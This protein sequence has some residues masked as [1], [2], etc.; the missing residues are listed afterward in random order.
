MFTYT[1]IS[2]IL[3]IFLITR[4]L[5]NFV[6]YC[7]YPYGYFYMLC[8]SSIL[9]LHL[10][11]R[12]IMIPITIISGFLG[13]GKTTYLQHILNCG[14]TNERILIIENDFGETSLDAKQLSTSGATVREVTSGC[15]CC[16]LQ[17][18]FKNALIDILS[19]QDIDQIYIEPSGVSKLSEILYT[20]DDDD[21]TSK[22]YVS[23]I[24][25][26]VD[27]MQ[28]PMAIKNFGPFFKDQIKHCYA[29]LLT[30]VEDEKQ[31]EK[32]K[33]LI[34]ELAPHTPVYTDVDALQQDINQ[35]KSNTHKAHEHDSETCSCHTCNDS[36]DYNGA[37]HDNHSHHNH[38]GHHH[39]HQPFVTHTFHNLQSLDDTQ[40]ID[41]C[42]NLPSTILRV[43]GIIPTASG[44][45]ELQY[46]P[47]SCAITATHLNDYHLVVIGTE[48]DIPSI[49]E[50][51]CSA[52]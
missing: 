10:Q 36:E 5:L 12:R 21:I 37:H 35:L 27:A 9:C 45:M 16:S 19:T 32:T 14:N 11:G 47:Q 22:A 49:N 24:I 15:I 39:E 20:C 7:L 30:H 29:M 6:N 25:T 52:S 34:V 4:L 26:V 38:D 44:P 46:T 40:W 41:F 1:H 13:A 8:K 17:G 31:V 33:Q 50:K 23:M 42:N 3:S 51:V 43:K 18:N 48:I 28:A 2:I